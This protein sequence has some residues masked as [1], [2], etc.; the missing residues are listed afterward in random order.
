MSVLMFPFI[1]YE[2]DNFKAELSLLR[3]KSDSANLSFRTRRVHIP[4][5]KRKNARE[6]ARKDLPDVTDFKQAR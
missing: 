2:G 3:I 6:D 4:G 1:D 5:Q